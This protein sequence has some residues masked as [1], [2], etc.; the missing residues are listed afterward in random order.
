MLNHALLTKLAWR[1][2]NQHDFLCVQLLNAKYFKIEEF[3]HINANK[4]ALPEYGKVLKLVLRIFNKISVLK[5][6]I[7]RRVESGMTVGS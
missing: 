2:C 4:I 7:I 1:I 5:L 6:R 3:I